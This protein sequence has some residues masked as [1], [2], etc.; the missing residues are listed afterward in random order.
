MCWAFRHLYILPTS[1][2]R[3]QADIPMS[4]SEE[5]KFSSVIGSD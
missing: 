2:R 5:S 4:I 3:K 1:E